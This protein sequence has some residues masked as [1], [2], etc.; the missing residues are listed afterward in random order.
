MPRSPDE[1][2]SKAQNIE[3]GHYMLSEFKGK[4]DARRA[5]RKRMKAYKNKYKF[6]IEDHQNPIKV[7][8][9]DDLPDEW[10]PEK[11]DTNNLI[12]HLSEKMD[13][14]D[15]FEN[16]KLG[17]KHHNEFVNRYNFQI[18]H[19][20]MQQ[21]HQEHKNNIE[22]FLERNQLSIHDIR[23]INNLRKLTANQKNQFVSALMKANVKK[24]PEE[25][26]SKRAPQG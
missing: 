15:N 18:P 4:F 3:S 13:K 19:S 2:K 6:Y 20:K 21:Q 16:I 1:Y 5:K 22:R 23:D 8:P 9:Q 10:I 11:G 7:G 25:T 12:L 14:Q 26:E 17:I 24:P